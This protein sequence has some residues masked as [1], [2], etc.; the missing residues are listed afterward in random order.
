MF[1]ELVYGCIYSSYVDYNPSTNVP[2]IDSCQTLKIYGC[3]DESADNFND[4]DGD[5]F[6]ND[7]T[8]I[9]GI[10]INTDDG[11]CQISGCTIY[12]P[13]IIMKMQM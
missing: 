13:L 5:G 2:D 1:T 12:W 8:G 7:I 4:Y 3:T 9:D 10:D 11:S 6:A